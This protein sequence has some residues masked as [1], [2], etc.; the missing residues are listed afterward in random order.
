MTI[1]EIEARMRVLTKNERQ[2]TAEIVTLIREVDRRRLYLERGFPSL[3]EWL[4]RNFGY[5]HSAAYRRIQAARLQKDIP[6]LAGKI[7]D[8]SLNLTTLAQVQ[9]AIQNHEKT[10]D[11]V[12]TVAK[13]AL[14]ARIEMKSSEE[15]QKI[16]AETFPNSI[17]PKETLRHIGGN[18]SSLTIVLRAK[19][20][21]ALERV[22]ELMAHSH[23]GASWTDIVSYALQFVV[24]SKDRPTRIAAAAAAQGEKSWAQ[25]RREVLRRGCEFVDPLSGRVC[26]SKYQIEVDH[27]HP[28]A[29]GGSDDVSNLRC[30]CRKHNLLMAERCFGRERMGK[31]W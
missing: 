29:L 10:G 20:R 24:K 7:A 11:K 31:Y 14:V 27:I 3:F 17:A 8:G 4:I 2:T 21:A 23:P 5:S 15:T 9:T 22:K 12:P 19:D 30:L 26:G 13:E 28:R 16:L 1:I 6:A 18:D 25:I